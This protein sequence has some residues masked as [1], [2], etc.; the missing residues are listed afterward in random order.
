MWILRFFVSTM[1]QKVMQ[2]NI[3]DT[4]AANLAT[5]IVKY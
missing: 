5:L 1:K 3:Y 4:F 2:G